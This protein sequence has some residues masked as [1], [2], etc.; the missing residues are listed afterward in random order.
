MRGKIV[1]GI[2]SSAPRRAALTWS[3]TR[4][5]ETDCTLELVHA[6][7]HQ[8]DDDYSHEFSQALLHDAE[9]LLSAELAFALG[10]YD[11]VTA[12]LERATAFDA[13][14]AASLDA[15]LVVVGTHKTGFIQGRTTGSRFLGLAS[16]SHCPVV[17]IPAVQL[18]SRRGVIVL[19]DESETGK[20]AIA[21]A[22][23]EARRLNQTLTLLHAALRTSVPETLPDADELLMWH[24]AERA[25]AAVEQASSLV[26]S[27]EP[28]V[29]VRSRTSQRPA[30]AEL[31]DAT[32][33]A[34]LVVVPHPQ[35]HRPVGTESGSLLLDVLINLGGPTLVVPRRDTE[36]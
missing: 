2:N 17:F 21:L 19:I 25:S 1:V 35:A 15:E 3:V 9:A 28:T 30:A 31:I 18:T 7:E 10:G 33:V 23:H 34:A 14:V 12:N 32:L 29:K 5:A 13:L 27:I 6:V 24:D 4:A 20:R 22:S 8:L 16:R 36:T 11:L 26:R